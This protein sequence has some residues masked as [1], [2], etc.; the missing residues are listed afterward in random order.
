[1]TGKVTSVGSF[2]VGLTLRTERMP[3][4]G[5]TGFGTDFDLG[6]GGKGSNQVV[7]ARRIGLD[8]EIIGLVGDDNFALIAEDLYDAEGVG[9]EYFNRSSDRNTAVAFIIL[10]SAGQNR[11]IVDPGANELVTPNYVE[12]ARSR[13]EDSDV[14]FTQLEISVEAAAAGMRL[15]KEAGAIALFNPAPARTVPPEVLANVDVLTPNESEARILLG[16]EPDDPIDDRDIGKRFLELGVTT[17]IIT[18]GERGALVVTKD[19]VMQQDAFAVDVVDTTG[20]GD[21]F[22]GALGAYLAMGTPLES[23]VRFAAAA[24]ALACTKLGVIPALA[25]RAAIEALAR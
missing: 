24:G 13:I 2:V 14:V 11:I 22:S 17:L 20:A 7:Q 16:L 12:K 21:A 6:P 25:D 10:D 5:E 18:Q 23:A 3:V 8:V 1:M 9:T 19:G 15:A 4:A